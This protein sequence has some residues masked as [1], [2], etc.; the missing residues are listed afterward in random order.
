MATDVRRTDIMFVV[1][2][3]SCSGLQWSK[4]KWCVYL[5]SNC[6]KWPQVL[7]ECDIITFGWFNC[8]RQHL[9][10]DTV[11]YHTSRHV[12]SQMEIDFVIVSLYC[13]N[14][15]LQKIQHSSHILLI[16]VLLK[17]LTSSMV[18]IALRKLFAGILFYAAVW[19]CWCWLRSDPNLSIF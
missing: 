17:S 12:I 19:C 10:P 8:W 13:K 16:G 3:R 7:Q 15:V 14:T 18:K 9:L 4:T 11:L 1:P 6:R 2:Q 5:Y